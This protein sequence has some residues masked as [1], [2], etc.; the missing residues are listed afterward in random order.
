IWSNKSH[1]P[2]LAIMAHWIGRN[3]STRSLQLHSALIAFH[4]L[5]KSLDGKCIARI[6]INL[7]DQA[8]IMVK[9]HR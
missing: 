6:V 3:K 5:C 4:H 9:V 2:F 8:G 7:L 1:Y